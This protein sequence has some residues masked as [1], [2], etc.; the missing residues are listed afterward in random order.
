L[1]A[2][3]QPAPAW[4]S[5]REAALF[6]RMPPPDQL[7]G[8]RVAGTLRAWGFAGDRPL[9]LA[10]LL[11]DLGKSLVPPRASYRM[12]MT[13]L[14]ALPPR[15]QRALAR[16]PLELL[17]RHAQLGADMALEAGLSRDVVG[18]IRDHH[19]PMGEARGLA[20]QRADALH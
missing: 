17:G 3:P 12:A 13:A 2:R 20:L 18:L 15:A 1:Q 11:H 7:E 6:Q 14:E 4:L 16:G 5:P 19:S 8:L 10:G 9:L